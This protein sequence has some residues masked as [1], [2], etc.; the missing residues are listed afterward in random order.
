MLQ[1]RSKLLLLSL[2]AVILCLRVYDLTEQLLL[3][4]IR[5][6][7]FQIADLETELIAQKRLSKRIREAEENYEQ[8][9]SS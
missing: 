2:V 3:D 7:E 1:Q 9:L 5:Q 4:P 8:W 6:K